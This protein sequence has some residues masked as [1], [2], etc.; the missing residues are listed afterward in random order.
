V[1]LRR[2]CFSI[3]LTSAVMLGIAAAPLVRAEPLPDRTERVIGLARVWAKAKFYHPYLAYKDI[4]WDAALVGAIPK[5]EAATTLAEYRAAVQGM[6]AALHDPVTRIIDAPAAAPEKAPADWLTTPSPGVLEVKLSALTAGGF[7]YVAMRAKG[8]QVGAEAAKAKVL[9]VDLRGAADLAGYAVE[10][11]LD[12]LPAIDAWPLERSLEH[13]GFRVQDGRTSGDYFSTFVTTGAQPPKPA[14]KAGVSHAVFVVDPDSVLPTAALAL[15]NAG[16]AAIVV[17]GAID[18]GSAVSTVTVALPGKLTARVRLGELL[19]GAPAADVTVARTDELEGRARALA[20]SLASTPPKAR[21]RKIAELPPLRARDDLDYADQA[22]PSRELRMLAGIRLWAVLDNFFPYRYLIA[23]WDAALR[24][25]LPQLAGV[26]DRDAY[27]RVLRQM[28]VRAGDGHI[29]VRPAV[30]DAAAKGR[31]GL[32]AIATRLVEG[33]LAVV[34]LLDAAEAK[35]QGLALGDVVETIDGKPAAQV[36][37]AG[38]AEMSASTDEARDQRIAAQ[39]LAG[40]DGTSVAL[41]VRGGDGTLRT[42]TLARSMANASA[43]WAK[44]TSPHWKKLPGNVGYVDLT[45]L[46]VPEV[47]PMFEDLKGTRAIVFDMRGYPNGTAWSIAPRINTKKAK[48]GAQFLQPLAVGAGGEIAD[49]RIRFLQTIPELPKDAW[50]YTGKIVVLIDDRAISQS[51]H[52][53]LFFESAAGATFI[54]SP[55]HGAN[56]DVTV[57]RLPGGLRMSF[58]GQ[59]VRHVDGRQL[60]RLGIQPDVVVRPTLAGLRAG[61]DDVLERALAW[62]APKG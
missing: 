31:G 9:I 43:L 12:A 59:E 37:A 24:D 19:W 28:S 50:I 10:Q 11:L 5:A 14:P 23:D 60:Q 13:H 18:E 8:M 25:A 42:V 52:S 55:T 29:G 4:D 33:K 51:E 45:A 15:Q 38:R 47:G 16:R 40:D 61:K 22:Y 32:P 30:P 3:A 49:Q 34:R 62:L 2:R 20:R 54:G 21:P 58:T 36:L 7:D 48:Y 46:L 35:K 44:S 53:C 41:G 17:Q 1:E 26:A 6:L 27:R 56:G 57:M 39:A